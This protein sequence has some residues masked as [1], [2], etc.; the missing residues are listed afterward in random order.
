MAGTRA[1]VAR[2][3]F[4]VALAIAGIIALAILLILLSANEGNMIVNAIVETGR[5]FATP[6]HEMFPLDNQDHS[7]ALN[8]CIGVAAYALV[9]GLAQRFLR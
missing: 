3:I 8:W 7:I 1:S 4:F 9:G 2:V 6:F 5:F